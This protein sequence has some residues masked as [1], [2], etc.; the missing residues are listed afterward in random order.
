VTLY[1]S[2]QGFDDRSVQ[3][4]LT[5]PRLAFA[6]GDDNITYG[7]EWGDT[8][9]RIAEP[10]QSHRA[11]LESLGWDVQLL[12]GLDHMTGMHSANVLPILRN[13]L[14]EYAGRTIDRL[15]H[16]E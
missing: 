5:V 3:S 12:L 11:E 2:L 9:V 1:E 14:E 7:A 8:V 6:G 4:G 10:L 15:E 16:H 13:A